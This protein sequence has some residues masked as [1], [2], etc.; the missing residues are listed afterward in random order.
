[1]RLPLSVE[2]DCLAATRKDALEGHRIADNPLGAGLSL[3]RGSAF[4]LA[5]FNIWGLVGRNL[6]RVGDV[7]RLDVRGLGLSGGGLLGEAQASFRRSGLRRVPRTLLLRCR[8]GTLPQ[9]T[10]ASRLGEHGR[11][12]LAGGA[13]TGGDWDRFG[14]AGAK[15]AASRGGLVVLAGLGLPMLPLGCV[16]DICKSRWLL[17]LFTELGEALSRAQEAARPPRALRTDASRLGILLA[18]L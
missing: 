15:V 3:P 16:L 1:V 17:G 18:L 5:C 2:A 4:S 12:G 11:G 14:A 13:G 10:S 6:S 8:Q 9:G 7:V